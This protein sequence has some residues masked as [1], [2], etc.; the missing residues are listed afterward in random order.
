MMPPN[1]PLYFDK[2]ETKGTNWQVDWTQIKLITS[3][4]QLIS[5]ISEFQMTIEN[6]L[7]ARKQNLLSL[8][9]HYPSSPQEKKSA[10]E[11]V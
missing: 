6:G 9:P 7:M 4:R 5:E 3:K 10:I 1:K 8:P 2:Q 11:Q